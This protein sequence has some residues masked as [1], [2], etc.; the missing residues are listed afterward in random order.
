MNT[1]KGYA[2]YEQETLTEVVEARAKATGVN[3]DP[4]KLNAATLRQFQQVQDG[5]GSALGKLLMIVEKYPDLKANQNYLELQAQLEG[6]E[7]RIAVERKKY[8]DAVATYNIKKFPG[9]FF[10]NFYGF[11]ESNGYLKAE[12]GAKE[13]PVVSFE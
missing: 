6:T 13:V 11:E 1:V 7:N 8:N 12:E 2:Q 3:I 5:L 10:N 4:S 9:V